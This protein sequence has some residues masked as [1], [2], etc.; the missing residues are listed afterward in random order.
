MTRP[1]MQPRC[2]A[3]VASCSGRGV[4]ASSSASFSSTSAAAGRLAA[5]FF[6]GGGGNRRCV[7]LHSLSLFPFLASRCF[8]GDACDTR[9]RRVNRLPTWILFATAKEARLNNG[10]TCPFFALPRRFFCCRSS[11]P[12]EMGEI[13]CSVFF[14]CSRLCHTILVVQR[15]HLVV[16]KLQAAQT[17]VKLKQKRKQ[18]GP[19]CSKAEADLPP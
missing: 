3:P 4:A 1:P 12:N 15:S 17:R 5:P 9:R 16:N 19:F 8:R 11:W 6:S 14:F 7:P 18:G 2:S 10:K 13:K